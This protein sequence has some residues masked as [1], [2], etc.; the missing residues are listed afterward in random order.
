MG[1]A[2]ATERGVLRPA[3]SM[4]IPL[5]RMVSLLGLLIVS[6]AASVTASASSARAQA[7]PSATLLRT[8]ASEGVS[9]GAARGFDRVL[10]QRVDELEGVDIAGSVELDLESVQLALGC[11]GESVE[12]LRAAAEQAGS[13]L[14]VFAS[15][16]SVGGSLVVSVMR[17]DGGPGVLRRALRTVASEAEVLESA[18]PIVRELWD[19]PPIAEDPQPTDPSPPRPLPARS[20]AP[21]P[22]VIAGV[23]GL[24]MVGGAI[25]MILGATSRDAYA[26]SRPTSA[27]QVDATLALLSAA[28]D[29]QRAG[30]ALLVAGGV[31]GIAG[32]IW[33]MAAGNEDGSSPLALSPIVGDG[34]LGLWVAGRLPGGAL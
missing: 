31:V 29:Q 11:M 26:A 14:L 22:I 1:R 4:A 8:H 25:A 34:Q 27:A 30:V 5:L 28:E 21:L 23:G 12:C 18:A 32:A 10:R 9:E 7:G 6:A 19:L 17:F 24:T 2:F 15:I 13:E 3:V 33:A 20:L 16:E